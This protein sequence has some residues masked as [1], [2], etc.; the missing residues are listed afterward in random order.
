MKEA[1]IY[2]IVAFASLVILGYSIHMFIGG[3]VS[4]TTERNVIMIA[5]G[6]GV[7]V[8]AFMGWDIVQKR[9]RPAGS[10]PR[11]KP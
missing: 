11:Q 8:L 6:I 4:E 5:C 10:D 2:I 9:K 7:V 1:F 3:L